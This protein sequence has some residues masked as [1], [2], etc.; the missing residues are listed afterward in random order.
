MSEKYAIGVDFGTLSARALVVRASDGAE[1]GEAVFEYTHSVM[2]RELPCGIKLCHNSALQDPADYLEALGK[3]I[4]EAMKTAGVDKEDICGIGVDF[5]NCTLIPVYSDG[6][7]LCF[8]EKYREEPHAYAKLWKHHAALDEAEELTRIAAE[9]GEDF[10]SRY[11]GRISCEWVFPKVWEILKRAPEV[12]RD[13]DRFVEAG[14]WVTW[15]LTGKEVHAPSYA[16]YKALWSADEGYPDTEFFASL[17]ERMRDI[18]GTKISKDI[19]LDNVKAGV[20][21]ERGAWLTSLCEGTPVAVA[22][23]DGHSPLPAMNITEAGELAIILGTS[24][25]HIVHSERAVSVP[26]VC[27]YAKYG[28]LPGVYTYE[29]GQACLGDGY[30]RFVRNFVP[31]SY[32][33]QARAEGINIHKFLREKAKKLRPGESGLICLDWFN[34]N[35]SVLVDDR[36]TGMILGLSLSTRPEEIYRALIEASA[37]GSRMIIENFEEHGVPIKSVCVAGGIARKDEMMMQIYADVMGREIKVAGSTQAAALGSAI[38]AAVAGGAYDSVVKASE[39]MSKPVHKV[40]YPNEDNRIVYEGLFEEYKRLH[41]YFGR[42]GN[43][44]M[45][46]MADMR[47]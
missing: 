23:P 30:D 7:P 13:T 45:R 26:G 25:P 5:T 42:G 27:G 36:L 28:A 31:E 8:D 24:A 43:D 6:T 1:L 32:S 44:V 21:G 2:E 3:V 11:G 14:D 22:M 18:V 9:R 15:M 35:R 37:F 47:R 4:P 16:G 29:A 10:L 12:Y 17:D 33:E 34:G 20:I 41:D 40:Y 38:Y 39:K 19:L 46:R